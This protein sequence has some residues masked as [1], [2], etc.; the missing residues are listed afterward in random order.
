MGLV[1]ARRAWLPV[2]A[3]VLAFSALAGALAGAEEPRLDVVF[4]LDQ[5][6]SMKQNDPGRLTEQAVRQ[7]VQQLGGEDAVGLVV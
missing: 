4:V 2:K 6:G 1:D 7:F 3:W 5:S